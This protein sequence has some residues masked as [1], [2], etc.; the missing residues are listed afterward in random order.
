MAKKNK[1][2]EVAESKEEVTKAAE[3]E[4]ATE[5]NEQKT[6]EIA[7]K[8]ET[9]AENEEKPVKEEPKKE[10]R[11]IWSLKW[12]NDVHQKNGHLK[13]KA[14]RW[15]I[16]K[17]ELPE[18]IRKWLTNKGYW[19]NIYLKSKEELEK[20]NVDLKMV[21]KLKKFISERYI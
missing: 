3:A 16:S 8:E 18:D 2:T 21:D 13:I 17:R 1:A 12:G 19:T 7:H 14:V 6:E 20:R 5:S 9:W 10:S 11:V 4:E 15:P